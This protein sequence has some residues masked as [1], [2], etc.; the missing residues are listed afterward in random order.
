TLQNYEHA[1]EDYRLKWPD[2]YSPIDAIY[3]LTVRATDDLAGNLLSRLNRAPALLQQGITNLSREDANPP[4][5][6]TE[7]AL[8]GAKGALNFLENL[9]NHP[10]IKSAAIDPSALHAA[11]EKAKSA[12]GDFATFL[13]GDL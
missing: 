13:D 12:V 10:K 11:I 8:E 4:K 7:M 1:K 9:P 2:T 3:I 6:W 5:L